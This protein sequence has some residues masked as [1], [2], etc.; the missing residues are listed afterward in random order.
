[1]ADPQLKPNPEFIAKLFNLDFKDAKQTI[2]V[3]SELIRE[4]FSVFPLSPDPEE[5][6]KMIIMGSFSP[7]FFDKETLMASGWNVEAINNSV[8]DRTH[9]IARTREL[10]LVTYNQ[11]LNPVKILS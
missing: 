4:L 6:Q 8:L 11:L 1:M 9:I 3:V 7:V 5:N 2:R 10:L